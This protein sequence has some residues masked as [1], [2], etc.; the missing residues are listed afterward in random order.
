MLISD[1]QH[2]A[3]CENAQKS[4]GPKTEEGKAAVRFN[5]LTWTLRARSLMLPNDNPGEYQKLWNALEEEF[6]PE[7]HN[8][9]Y[10]LEQI[11]AAEWRLARLE[12]TES[13]IYDEP[14]NF[15]RLLRLL[16][17][18][19]IQRARLER[20]R[21]SAVRTLQQL[22]NERLARDQ[23]PR[24][25]KPVKAARPIE[26]PGPPAYLMSEAGESLPLYCAPADTDTR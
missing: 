9:R 25:P 15:N 23:K 5:A 7:T 16:E 3:N 13:K 11:A 14:M 24:P 17:R 18:V 19:S 20:S 26:P 6:Q 1:K 4:T 21:E 2:A 10:Y 12:D 8:E 22:R